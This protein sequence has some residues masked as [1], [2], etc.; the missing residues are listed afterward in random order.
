MK[1]TILITGGSD[2]VGKALAE[3]LSDIYQ[4]VILSKDKENTKNV[5]KE[6]GV[7][8]VVADVTK[9]EEVKEAVEKVIGKY[10][11]IDVLVNN[12]GIWTQ[13]PIEENEDSVIKS[14]LD[15][16]TYGTILMTKYV[17]PHMKK[18]KVGK[19]INVISQAGLYGK[20]ERSIYNTSKWA[21]TGFTKSIE[22][23]LSKFGI[24]VNGF[25]PGAIK[26]DIFKKTG[27]D[28]NMDDYIEKEDVVRVLRFIL[29]TKSNLNLPEIGIKSIE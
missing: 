25:Y 11:K 2:G 7:D 14:I 20:A 26:T 27:N 21:I 23:E 12:A 15:V 8:F 1:K 17:V 22:M 9:P 19:I 5:A 29:E 16:N 4:V 6:I 10:Q 13:G 18:E 28:R 24:S 3:N